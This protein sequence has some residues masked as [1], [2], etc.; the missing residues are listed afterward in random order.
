LLMNGRKIASQILE[1]VKE[2][3]EEKD[4][5][6]KLIIVRVGRSAEQEVFIRSKEKAGKKVG[7]AVDVV[8]LPEN[9]PQKQLNLTL[10]S[11]SEDPSVDGILLQLPIPK[12]LSPYNAITHITPSKDVDVLHPY[13]LGRLIYGDESLAPCTPSA[14]LT[15]LEE[16]GIDLEG[17]NVVVVNN[18]ILIGKPLFILLTNRFATVDVCH[19]KTVDLKSHT[20]RAD[21][22]I[23]ATGV[24]ELIK[25]SMIKEGSVIVD[26]G[27]SVVE[28]KVL[29]DVSKEVWPKARYITPVP[30]GVGPVTV[31][32]VMRNLLHL[33]LS[34][35]QKIS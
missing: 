19:I 6:P 2:Q 9:I 34:Q 32:M 33:V 3:I 30:G 27:I 28:G 22:V 24:P 25:S 35:I 5:N 10:K 29:G 16:Y 4:L 20:L 12:H 31:A 21:I 14:I 8:Q 26:A 17:K 18:S 11:L 23:T 13:N 15:I 1:E 7:V